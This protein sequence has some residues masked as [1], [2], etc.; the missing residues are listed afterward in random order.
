ML[1]G[2]AVAN[3]ALARSEVDFATL[4]IALS[5]ILS[6]VLFAASERLLVP[7]LVPQQ[8]APDYDPIEGPPAPVV[9]CGFGRV[10]QIVG[11]V[12]HMR[13]I[14]FTALDKSSEQIEVVRRFGGKVYFG[15]P[16]REDVLRAPPARARRSC[17]WSRW[18]TRRRRWPWPTW[19]AGTSRTSSSSPVRGTAGTR[20]C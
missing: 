10:G 15:N 17:W 12:L 16:A 4:V 5:M 8:E 9:I 3:G 2:A 7:R 1:F 11:R 18:T 19:P 20:T 13:G 14:P 6:P